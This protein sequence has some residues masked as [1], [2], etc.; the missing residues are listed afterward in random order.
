MIK[1]NPKEI[2]NPHSIY[3]HKEFFDQSNS[4]GGDQ[5]PAHKVA[6]QD[7]N[8]RPGTYAQPSVASQGPYIRVS[9]KKSM[10]IH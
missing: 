2:I 5:S 3:S 10:Q 9:H 7:S 1:L 6:L 8:N 4:R